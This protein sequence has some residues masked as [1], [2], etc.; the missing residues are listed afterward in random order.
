VWSKRYSINFYCICLTLLSGLAVFVACSDN[1]DNGATA[2]DAVSTTEPCYCDSGAMGER[3]CGEDMV[4]G[5]CL[6]CEWCCHVTDGR[7]PTQECTYTVTPWDPT[8]PDRIDNT[9]IDP[10]SCTDPT[11]C[12]NDPNARVYFQTGGNYYYS[13]NCSE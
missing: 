11:H 4:F 10:R 5:P 6:D 7:V 13:M 3:V 12:A 9:T 1:S 2:C 8:Q